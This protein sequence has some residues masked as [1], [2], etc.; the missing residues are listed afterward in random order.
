MRKGD[1]RVDDAMW[2]AQREAKALV[3][4]IQTIDECCNSVAIDGLLNALDARS[5][6]SR[7]CAEKLIEVVRGEIRHA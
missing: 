3:R 6:C 7:D 5:I 1:E 4:I 2:N